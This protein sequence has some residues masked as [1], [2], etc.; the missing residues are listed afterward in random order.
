M[1]Y[2]C[3]ITVNAGQVPSIQNGFTWVALEGNFPAAAVDGGATSVLNGGGNLRC[4]TDSTKTTRIP[5][6]VVTFV[7]GGAPDIQVWGLSP[8]LGVGSTVYIEADSVATAQPAV[9]A[10]FGRNAVYVGEINRMHMESTNPVDST[11]NQTAIIANAVAL[12]SGNIGSALRFNGTS[13]NID[14][15]AA[16]LPVGDFTQSV[17]FNPDDL[18]SFQGLIGNWVSGANGRTYLGLSSTAYNW[19]GYATVSNTRQGAAVGV[20]QMLT[21]TRFEGV[22]V[23]L[24]DGVQIGDEISDLGFPNSDFNTFIG[25][26]GAGTSFFFDGLI[27]DNFLSNVYDSADK[28]LAKYNNQSDP[29]AFWATSAWE[30]QDADGETIAADAGSYA[31]TGEAVT[32]TAQ[33]RT[34]A[35]A[36]SYTLTG[37]AVTLTA[38]RRTQADA[39]SYALTGADVSFPSGATLIADAGSY[40]LTGEAVT[41]TAQ[42]RTQADAGSY[43]LTGAA[44]QLTAQRRTQADAGSYALTGAAVDFF[45]DYVIVA[46]QGTYTLTGASVQLT[47]SGDTSQVIGKITASFKPVDVVPRYADAW[48]VKF[49]EE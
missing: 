22:A 18:N 48:T 6:E 21:V 8:T 36:G 20:W 17:W 25:A 47:H 40:A 28:T 49:K 44:V 39:G 46:E 3:T 16:I 26:L 45:A 27:G 29:S 2:G 43:T 41:L 19:D 38:Q 15:G 10:A 30:N 14:L 37:E 23:V 9:G 4:Y 32:L 35:D 34:Q 33:R 13:S 1:A 42:R 7:T 12:E 24:V 31:L 11:G 5:I